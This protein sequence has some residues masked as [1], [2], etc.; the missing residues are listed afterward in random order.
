M[1]GVDEEFHPPELLLPKRRRKRSK[2]KKT[3]S[4]AKRVASRAKPSRKGVAGR[5][6]LGRRLKQQLPYDSSKGAVALS[7]ETTNRSEK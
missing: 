4:E 1:R 6:K 2:K 7:R 5:A 3:R